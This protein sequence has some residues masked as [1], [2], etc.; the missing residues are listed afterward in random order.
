MYPISEIKDEGM[1]EELAQAIEGL[2]QG[3]VPKMMFYKRGVVWGEA[4]KS[5][6]RS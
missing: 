6:L 5:F 3:S 4:V 2:E 1:G